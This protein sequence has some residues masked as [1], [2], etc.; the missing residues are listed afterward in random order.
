MIGLLAS[1]KS[2][3]STLTGRLTSGRATALDN[4]DAAMTTRLGSIKSI[5]RGTI[6]VT[7]DGNGV[8]NNTAT[9]SSVTTSKSI[10]IPLGL[11]V[12]AVDSTYVGISRIELTNGTTVTAYVTGKPSTAHTV[13]YQVVEFN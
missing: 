10:I 7:T 3:I 2:G 1:I 8:G 9:I 12:G 6:S 4:L 5:A 13:G 11:Y